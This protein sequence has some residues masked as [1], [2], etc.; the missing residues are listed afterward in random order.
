MSRIIGVLSIVIAALT[1]VTSVFHKLSRAE[2]ENEIDAVEAEIER[3]KARLDE[4]CENA[5][6][7]D[8]FVASG[9]IS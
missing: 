2:N 4:L 7:I 5:G 9:L 1:V 6:S 3:L 8:H